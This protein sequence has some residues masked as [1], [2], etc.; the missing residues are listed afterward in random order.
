MRL[1]RLTLALV[2]VC[3]WF[4]LSSP[5]NALAQPANDNF[6]NSTVVSSLPFADSQDLSTATTEPGEPLLC[7]T[8]QTVWYQFTPSSDVTVRATTVGSNFATVLNIWRA[9]GPGFPGLT[10]LTCSQFGNQT[11]FLAHAGQTYY[12][13]AGNV[14]GGF[15]TVQLQLQAVPPPP[16]DNFADAIPVNSLP[17]ADTQDVTGAT[18]EPGEPTNNCAGG[19]GD[20]VWYSFTPTTS[21][22]YSASALADEFGTSGANVYTGSSVDSLTKVACSPGSGALA[23]WSATAGTTYYIQAGNFNGF[24]TGN[25][26]TRVEVTP[27]PNVSFFFGPSDPSIFDTLSF[28]AVSFD[29]ANIGVETYSWTFGDGASATG[30][31]QTHQY[32][33][34]GDYT[35]TLTGTTFD[36]RVG[37]Q[38]A[39]MHVRT[40]D[41]AITSFSAPNTAKAGKTATF[42]VRL[43]DLRDPEQVEVDLMKSDPTSGFVTVASRVQGVQVSTTGKTAD[44][45]LSYTFT[46]ADAALRDVTFKAVATIIGARDAV[47]SNN[48]AVAPPTKVMP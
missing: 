2:A 27:P 4:A 16:N 24:T 32:A 19:F 46:S 39:V 26:I 28:T 40:H 9:D 1:H 10:L 8:Q 45:K 12:I 5:S 23:A 35:V 29:P 7:G 44:F 43:S 36:G 6:A 21:G 48:T 3:G 31:C 17:F 20:S 15:G 30:C 42:D 25:L 14:A 18:L 11:V 37:I 33:K 13:Q 41:V 34:D 47:P 22:S 38:T